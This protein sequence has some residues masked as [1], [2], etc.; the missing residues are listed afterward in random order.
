MQLSDTAPEIL[1]KYHWPGN[2]SE[3]D[4]ALRQLLLFAS[5]TIISN[6]DAMEVLL[7][8]PSDSN[9]ELLPLSHLKKAL[10]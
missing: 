7:D 6:G 10:I 4:K 1:S 8:L 5:E 2:D 9:T 3:L